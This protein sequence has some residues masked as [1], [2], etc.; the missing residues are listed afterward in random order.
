[1]FLAA[2]VA[3]PAVAQPS[4]ALKPVVVTATR[5][6]ELADS[7][8]FGVSVITA[9]EIRRSGATTV[10]EA[11]VRVLGVVGRLDLLGGGEYQID[12]RGFGATADVNQVVIV[13]GVRL[14][15][16]DL[17]GTRLSGI[18]IESVE[19][20]EVLRG[21]GAVLY[22]EGATAG[23]IVVTTRSGAGKERAAGGTAYV[24]AGT[25]GLRDLRA[26]GNVGGQGFSL[27]VS[28]QK[29]DTDGHRDNF[30][31]SMDAASATGQWSNE[32]LRLGAR[33]VHDALDTGLPGA[34]TAA[35]YEAN[36][37]QSNTPNDHASTRN[38]RGSVFG[39]AQL[40]SWQVALDAGK[41][42]R[43]LRSL[44]NGFAF[45]YDIEA[46]NYA[47]RAR[48]QSALGTASNVL[49]AGFD[50]QRWSRD[51]LGLFGSTAQQRTR[52]FYLKDDLTLA[53]GT[54]LALGVRSERADKEV[55]TTP[56]GVDDRQDAWELGVSQPLMRGV[57]A[58]GR[59]G[60]SFRFPNVD[61]FSFASPGIL[62]PQ[63]SRDYEMGL[64]WNH[65]T[66]RVDARLYRSDLTNEIGFDPNAPGPFGFP[67]ANTNFDPTR[68]QGLELDATQQAS[69]ALAL[70]V[71]AALREAKFRSGPYA[72]K[73][74]P[75]AP[76]QTLALR[77]DWTPL[78]AHRLSG[79]IIWVSSQHPDFQNACTMPS[80]T[81]IDAR[82]S[83][84]W[85]WAELS[86]SVSNLA[87]RKF[88]TQAFACDAGTTTSIYPEAGRAF[89]AS[90]RASF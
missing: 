10:N 51:V 16:A 18:P 37:R 89:V 4:V 24:G 60:R 6:P 75:L 59:L 71:N 39:E 72:G 20:I 50:G 14:S 67:G 32:W 11:L 15:E 21:S 73:D 77:A 30:Q 79:G 22:G 49:L 90:L 76:S 28:G 47:L 54:R 80:Y 35:Q 27:D 83:Y 23:V 12:L 36:P 70:R 68:R 1:M 53:A 19:R 40:G 3:L 2:S 87:D 41:R 44:N 43:T 26:T 34:L 86:L 69:A 5:F 38:S 82:Y 17:G 61:E 31:S 58:Y 74:I 65:A 42:E 33:Y 85:R 78:P 81:T 29:R 48:N 7:L 45:D 56:G 88:Y 62:E 25:Y 66:G 8:P 46:E 52:A 84:L 13:D 63:T 55:S 9:D 64:R 57:T